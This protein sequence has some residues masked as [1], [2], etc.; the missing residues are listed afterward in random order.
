MA[1]PKTPKMPSIPSPLMGNDQSM[2]EA[3]MAMKAA[4]EM[5]MG[6]RGVS[7]ASRVFVNDKMP[8]AYSVGDLWVQPATSRLSYWNGSA[9]VL[10]V[11]V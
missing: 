8:E 5:L 2:H 6:T 3:L 7:P 1:D 11:G 4:L 10:T 9:W